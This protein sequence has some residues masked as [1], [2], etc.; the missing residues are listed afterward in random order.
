MYID[1]IDS[2]HNGGTMAKYKKLNFSL[3]EL[4]IRTAA[5]SAAERILM[6]TKK[7]ASQYIL[8]NPTP[9]YPFKAKPVDGKVMNRL[10]V[11]RKALEEGSDDPDIV[12]PA[13][14]LSIPGFGSIRQKR[15]N[16]RRSKHLTVGAVIAQQQH[17]FSA[18]L[19]HSVQDNSLAL[20]RLKRYYE[21]FTDVNKQELAKLRAF[22]YKRAIVERLRHDKKGRPFLSLAFKD[23]IGQFS[24]LFNESMRDFKMKGVSFDV[25]FHI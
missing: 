12:T 23:Q 24:V 1:G 11:L 5:V 22:G 13:S 4:V 18:R 16:M 6:R 19:I 2:P 14:R 8:K 17:G 3:N 9:K 7:N 25:E 21:G 20:Q 10:G 15:M